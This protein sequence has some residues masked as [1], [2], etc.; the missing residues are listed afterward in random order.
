MVGGLSGGSSSLVDPCAS[1]QRGRARRIQKG[2]IMAAAAA[3]Q[4]P[5]YGA[6][7]GYHGPF[8]SERFITELSEDQA[9]MLARG[10]GD[11]HLDALVE[12]TAPVARILSR[13]RGTL[14]LPSLATIEPETCAALARHRGNLLLNG[15][16]ALSPQQATA[17]VG[18]RDWLGLD[19]LETV[20]D[21]VAEALCRHFG[22]VSLQGVRT[23]SA[24]A[25]IALRS[26]PHIRLHEALT[27]IPQEAR[28][29]RGPGDRR[30][31]RR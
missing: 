11:V 2:D 14:S 3:A 16:R 13:H 27:K 28:S 15:L 22:V 29:D 26:C 1:L 31:R 30:H 4:I 10:R 18:H 12:I 8:E 20:S 23:V 7:D 24:A 25:L 21:E 6:P 19:G 9:A 5:P 17:L